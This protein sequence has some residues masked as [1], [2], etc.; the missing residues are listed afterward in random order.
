[1]RFGPP[2]PTKDGWRYPLLAGEL[3]GEPGGSLEIGWRQGKLFAAVH[4]YR[5]A[6]PGPVY[7]WTQYLFHHFQTRVVLLRLRG[8]VPETA[9]PATPAAR[10]AAG[11]IDLGVCLL[12]AGGKPRRALAVAAGYHL[13]A[14]ALGG[15]TAGGLLLGQR[16]VA[17]DG[18]AATPGQAAL[19]LAA[20]PLALLRLRAVHDE[21]AGT[22]VVRP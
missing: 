1:M 5:P 4:G 12:L 16:V 7:R 13:G 20:L 19:R 15:Y 11:A 2:E 3:L 9:P 10:L 22:E 8:R 14:W 17:V 6:L 18:S 21:V